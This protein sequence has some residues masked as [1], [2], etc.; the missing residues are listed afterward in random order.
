[1]SPYLFV[2]SMDNLLHIIA[3]E[4]NVGYWKPMNAKRERF[5]ISHVLFFRWP[6]SFLQRLL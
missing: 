5:E 2:I 4:V 1:M 3:G 6:S